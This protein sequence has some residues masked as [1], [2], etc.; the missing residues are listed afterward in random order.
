MDRH[1]LCCRLDGFEEEVRCPA[2]SLFWGAAAAALS[3]SFSPSAVAAPSL[4]A[5]AGASAGAYL[6]SDQGSV[7][8]TPGPGSLTVTAGAA[9]S[10]GVINDSPPPASW[11]M[12]ALVTGSGTA[13]YGALAGLAHAEASSKPA[14]TLFLAGG[15]VSL[16]LGFTDGAEVLS[17]TLDPGTP[18][19][20]TF[21]MTLDATAVHVTD[22]PNANPEDTGAAARHEVEVRDLDNITQP[23]G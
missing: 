12:E 13:R 7:L 22:Q 20:L 2:P 4:K 10:D 21:L 18:V 3:L 1:R 9:A 17:D 23:S 14:N 6:D 16:D 11:G 8:Q 5:I 15:Q 19:T